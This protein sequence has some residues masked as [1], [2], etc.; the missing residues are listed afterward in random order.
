[1]LNWIVEEL[2]DWDITRDIT[3][4]INIPVEGNDE[5]DKVFY[6]WFDNHLCYISSFI[7]L[8]GNVDV[9]ER[10]GINL[11]YI[12]LLEKILF[13]ITISFCQQLD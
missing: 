10:N 3:W 13:I 8:L 6:G 4:G 1:M 9:A 7:E 12:T 11:K 5:M 2:Q